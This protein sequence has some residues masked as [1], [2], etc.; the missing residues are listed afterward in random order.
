MYFF[1]SVLLLS[2]KADLTMSLFQRETVPSEDPQNC[3]KADS[4]PLWAQIYSLKQNVVQLEIL[5]KV[6]VFLPY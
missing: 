3:V 5:F 2:T 4:F 6:F 1:H